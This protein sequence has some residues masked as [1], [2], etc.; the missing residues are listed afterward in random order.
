MTDL[1]FSQL[2][3]TDACRVYEESKEALA[4]LPRR[5]KSP[6][7]APVRWIATNGCDFGFHYFKR[8]E[9]GNLQGFH[10]DDEVCEVIEFNLKAGEAA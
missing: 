1:E 10:G 6:R 4:N 2:D 5:A 8:D 7:P 3:A 9:A